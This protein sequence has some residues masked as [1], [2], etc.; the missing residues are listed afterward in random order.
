MSRVTHAVLGEVPEW[1]NRP[2]DPVYPVALF[3]A[4]RVKIRDE[5]L[6]RNKAL[7]DDHLRRRQGGP[8]VADR[9][10]RGGQV[11]AQGDERT[12][13][14]RGLG[15]SSSR[16]WTGSRAFPTPS[17][18]CSRAS[19]SR[20]HLNSAAILSDKPGP[21]HSPASLPQCEALVQRTDGAA[22]DRAPPWWKR[23][24]ASAVSRPTGTYPDSTPPLKRIGPSPTLTPSFT[25][26]P[27]L[28]DV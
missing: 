4:L 13:R 28:H 24:G 10:D 8:G 22:L 19:R 20:I 11:L 6:V 1:Q 27:G 2:L 23:R 26:K 21:P 5:G 7:A 18:R 17:A 16:W 9:A 25:L 3:D 14:P 12:P 15:I